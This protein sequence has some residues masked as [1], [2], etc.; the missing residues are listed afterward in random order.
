MSVELL[1][2]EHICTLAL[3]A[4]TNLAVVNIPTD[5]K[6][7]TKCLVTANIT[8][9]AAMNKKDIQSQTKD[10][11]KLVKDVCLAELNNSRK[12]KY[13]EKLLPIEILRMAQHTKYNFNE[14]IGFK[15][16]KSETLL[17][18]IEGRALRMVLTPLFAKLA[19]IPQFKT[20]TGE[21]DIDKHKI[22]NRNMLPTIEVK[23]P[24]EEETLDQVYEDELI[25]DHGR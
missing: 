19:D 22:E 25:N 1:N 6:Q 16:I 7:A 10:F 8:A 23:E 3:W 15:D 20:V 17:K 4:E 24:I 18:H 12:Q 21:L 9:Y 5:A 13:H 2:T 14:A 11:A